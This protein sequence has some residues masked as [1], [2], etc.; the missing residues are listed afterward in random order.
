MRLQTRDDVPPAQPRAAAVRG[1]GWL[2]AR[3]PVFRVR[4]SGSGPVLGLKLGVCFGLAVAVTLIAGSV[5]ALAQRH[6]QPLP[7]KVLEL[8]K[9][10]PRS[11]TPPVGANTLSQRPAKTPTP[12]STIQETQSCT[13]TIG[14]MERVARGQVVRLGQGDCVMKFNTLR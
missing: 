9:P 7:G 10:M 12:A 4:A 14:Q 13:L 11:T 6:V 2:K 5:P 3:S 8:S 1:G